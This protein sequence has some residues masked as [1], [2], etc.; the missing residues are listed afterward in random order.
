MGGT[1]HEALAARNTRR[2]G[3]SD[4]SA[5]DR[6]CVANARPFIARPEGTPIADVI[7][8][9]LTS[10]RSISPL[11]EPAMNP[12]RRVASVLVP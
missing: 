9:P 12:C 3:A 6:H 8:P 5:A 4:V 10:L 2:R 7:Y 1:I 11:P